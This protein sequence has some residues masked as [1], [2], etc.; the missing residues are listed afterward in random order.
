MI[1]DKF[2][3]VKYIEGEIGKR[4]F[5]MR[6]YV[7]KGKGAIQY[8]ADGSNQDFKVMF[9]RNVEPNGEEIELKPLKYTVFREDGRSKPLRDFMY[10]MKHLFT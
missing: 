6:K 9:F 5:H 8:R 4:I 7:V 2:G 3:I 10:T 1:K